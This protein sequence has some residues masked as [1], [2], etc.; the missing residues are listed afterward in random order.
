VLADGVDAALEQA[1]TT[2]ANATNIMSVDRL[3]KD[4]RMDI[5]PVLLLPL[6]APFG[7]CTGDYVTFRRPVLSPGP[8]ANRP[9]PS[10]KHR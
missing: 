3:A 4:A 8:R 10:P 9:I 2:R 6:A 5:W 1:P 7:S